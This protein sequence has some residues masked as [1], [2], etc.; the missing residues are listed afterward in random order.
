MTLAELVSGVTFGGEIACEKDQ[1]Y[2]S[3]EVSHNASPVNPI[4][5]GGTILKESVGLV[6]FGV[7]YD[8]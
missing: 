2:D 6:L 8:L 1:D 5:V 7:T 3:L 4:N